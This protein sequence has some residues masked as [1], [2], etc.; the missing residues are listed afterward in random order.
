MEQIGFKVSPRTIRMIGRQNVSNQFVA[1]NELVKNSYDAD[2]ESVE[3]KF[4]GK[5]SEGKGRI[6]IRDYGLGMDIDAIINKWL[7]IGTDNKER[8]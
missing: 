2:S 4:R 1:I 6:L 3:I 8:L 5:N 7:T